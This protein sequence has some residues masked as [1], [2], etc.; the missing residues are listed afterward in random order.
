MIEATIEEASEREEIVLEWG[1][2]VDVSRARELLDQA[3]ACVADSR[4]LVVQCDALER[5]DASGLQILLVL[6]RAVEAA[7]GHFRLGGLSAPVTASLARA[8]ASAL[9][10]TERPVSE[11]S[12]SARVSEVAH[13]ADAGPE[14]TE[15]ANAK[16][17]A[18]ESADAKSEDT[19]SANAKSEDAE[20]ANAESEETE[21]ADAGWEDTESAAAGSDETK[22]EVPESEVAP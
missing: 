9:T 14:D 21:S 13:S 5:I 4:D 8:G 12:E 7:G 16:S 15:S 20:S 3:R 2:A 19:E 22:P 11:G 10:A 1:G 18:A 6:K 17:D